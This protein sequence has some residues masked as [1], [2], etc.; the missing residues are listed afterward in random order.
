M[1]GIKV[2]VGLLVSFCCCA[3]NCWSDEKN[4]DIHGPAFVSEE[5]ANHFHKIVLGFPP[6]SE[7]VAVRAEI[8]SSEP[9]QELPPF[10]L[11]KENF[12]KLLAVFGD[13]KIDTNP[14]FNLPE[15][16]CIVVSYTNGR[17]RRLCWYG[18]VSRAPLMFS[19]DGV[20]CISNKERAEVDISRV[21]EEIHEKL[22][23]PKPID[24]GQNQRPRF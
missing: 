7:I 9:S 10:S 14:M 12:E 6:T 3:N 17:K 23:P 24:K 8:T 2:A 15:F 1:C 21:I 22:N 13:S 18:G 19:V 20:R 5:A 11:P 16:G 4:R